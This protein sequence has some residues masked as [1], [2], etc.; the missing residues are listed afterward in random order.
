[1]KH[2]ANN[3][4]PF[5]KSSN[6]SQSLQ[7]IYLY[8]RKICLKYGNRKHTWAQ[9]RQIHSKVFNANTFIFLHANTFQE[10]FKYF[11]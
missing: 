5:V 10:Y 6:N 1:M 8:N 3:I 7:S 11:K 4:A 9:N 2:L